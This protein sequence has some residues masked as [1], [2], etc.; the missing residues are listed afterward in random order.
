[1]ILATSGRR[2]AVFA[3]LL[4]L[5]LLGTTPALQSPGKADGLNG[6]LLR[7]V[8]QLR[9]TAPENAG[10][11]RDQIRS[12]SR[13]RREV[14]EA[15]IQERPAEAASLAFPD[16]LAVELAALAPSWPLNL[17]PMD[18]GRSRWNTSSKTMRR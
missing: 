11:L 10:A 9:Q 2:V 13:Q 5:C 6:N 12:L 14:L 18:R 4:S 3:L 8:S 15:L 1:M 7:L 16:A 17:K